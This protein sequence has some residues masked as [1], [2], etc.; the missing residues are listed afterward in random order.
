M[1]KY[2]PAPK[3]EVVHVWCKVWQS[4][5]RMYNNR[6]NTRTNGNSVEVTKK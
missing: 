4:V 3:G 1:N 6:Y 2:P 5:W